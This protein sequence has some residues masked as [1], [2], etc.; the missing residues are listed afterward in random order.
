[1]N[2]FL[3]NARARSIQVEATLNHPFAAQVFHATSDACELDVLVL[4]RSDYA[5]WAHGELWKWGDPTPWPPM[6][7]TLAALKDAVA[8]WDSRKERPSFLV[9]PEDVTWANLL[10]DP[11]RWN[12]TKKGDWTWPEAHVSYFQDEYFLD[13]EFEPFSNLRLYDDFDVNIPNDP[14]ASLNRTY[15]PTCSYMAR[16]DEHGGVL[17]DLRKPEHAKL[18]E[19]APVALRDVSGIGLTDDEIRDY[20]ND[21]RDA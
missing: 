15:G 1:M 9:I 4:A 11:A 3:W 10:F 21:K 16:V 14:W 2:V 20:Y 13:S 12:R 19:P 18:R 6:T 17:A 8:A 5:P 7:A